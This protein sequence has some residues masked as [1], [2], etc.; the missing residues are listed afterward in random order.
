MYKESKV[1]DNPCRWLTV[2]AKNT[3][4]TA[5]VLKRESKTKSLRILHYL[6]YLVTHTKYVYF[7]FR[8]VRYRCVAVIVRRTDT[9]RDE[10]RSAQVE[11]KTLLP[12]VN[13]TILATLCVWPDFEKHCAL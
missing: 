11:T 8:E 9:H 13:K 7:E 5:T 10:T 1:H 12:W 6:K 2:A 3:H 4:K